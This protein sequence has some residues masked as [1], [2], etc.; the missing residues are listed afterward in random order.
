MLVGDGQVAIARFKE[1]KFD[2]AILD[3]MVPSIDGIGV[4]ESIRL[5]DT[6][7][8]ILFYQPKELLKIVY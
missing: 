5:N 1:E 4:A 6:K 7:I 2:L 8:P 3:I